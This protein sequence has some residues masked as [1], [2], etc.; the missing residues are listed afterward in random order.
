M[1]SLR[2]GFLAPVKSDMIQVTQV[3]GKRPVEVVSHAARRVCRLQ[4]AGVEG[5]TVGFGKSEARHLRIQC[6]AMQ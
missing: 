4:H 3:N 2:I 6:E 5:L 1:A